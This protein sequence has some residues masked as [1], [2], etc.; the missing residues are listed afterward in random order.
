[1]RERDLIPFFTM[2]FLIAWGIL[3]LYIFASEPMVRFF[4]NLTGEHPLFYLA[5]Y[6]PAIAA[7]VLVHYRHGFG[8]IRRFLSR[9]LL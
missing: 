1:M 6:A 8:G 4:G 7:L 5:V 9:L 2:A 3:G